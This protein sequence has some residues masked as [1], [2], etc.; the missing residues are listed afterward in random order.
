MLLRAFCKYLRQ[1]NI[2]F[3]QTYMEQ[4]LVRHPK[5]V[6]GL[7]RLFYARFQPPIPGRRPEPRSSLRAIWNRPWRRWKAWTKTAF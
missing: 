4:A 5:I 2:A 6:Q 7:I 3:S 1:T